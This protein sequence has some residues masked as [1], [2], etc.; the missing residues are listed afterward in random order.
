[1][2]TTTAKTRQEHE[3]P[4]LCGSCPPR[5][6]FG[7]IRERAKLLDASLLD[8]SYSDGYERQL[9]EE[10]IYAIPA[11]QRVQALA[12]AVGNLLFSPALDVL[13]E[14]SPG[15]YEAIQAMADTL[16]AEI[17]AQHNEP[18]ALKQLMTDDIRRQQ[19]FADLARRY[20]LPF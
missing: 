16:L 5:T 6:L 11:G 18:D 7:L 13:D 15:S 14:C 12:W 4:C 2:T 1:M 19:E 8:H 20:G 17:R 9:A 3:Q 10:L